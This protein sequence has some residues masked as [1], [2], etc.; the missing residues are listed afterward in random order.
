MDG[1]ISIW[2]LYLMGCGIKTCVWPWIPGGHKWGNPSIVIC[3]FQILCL[4]FYDL[5][6][7]EA[8]LI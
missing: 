6:V 8:L 1:K 2:N 5:L 7:K 3:N 4:V